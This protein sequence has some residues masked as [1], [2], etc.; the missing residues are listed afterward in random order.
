M[1]VLES[2]AVVALRETQHGWVKFK[3]P[4]LFNRLFGLLRKD[5]G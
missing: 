3:P 5:Q 2:N 1:E 4:A